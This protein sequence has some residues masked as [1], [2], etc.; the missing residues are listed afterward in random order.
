LNIVANLS[1]VGLGLFGAILV[2]NGLVNDSEVI[3]VMG[4]EIELGRNHRI[5]IGVGL[6]LLGLAFPG[7]INWFVASARDANLFS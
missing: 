7:L 2:L 4:Q 5:A 1:E 3:D 6:I